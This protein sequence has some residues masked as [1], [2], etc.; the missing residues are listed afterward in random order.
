[1]ADEKTFMMVHKTPDIDCEKV[2]A[3]WREIAQDEAGT[4]II[5]Y[6]NKEKR[7]RYC[8][9]QADSEEVLKHIFTEI[10]ISWDSIIEVEALKPDMWGEKWE[11]HLKA[12]MY[13]DTLGD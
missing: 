10:G 2:Q 12:E 6:V 13:A 4:W 9:W 11:E 7:I 3:K 1:M 5:S 8:L